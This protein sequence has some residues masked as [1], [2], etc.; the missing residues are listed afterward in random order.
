MS[1]RYF[2]VDF[3]AELPVMLGDITLEYGSFTEDALPF[4]SEHYAKLFGIEDG[5][6]ARFLASPMTPAKVRFSEEMDVFLHRHEGR[7]VG[8]HLC[9]PSDWCSYYMRTTL[10]LPEYRNRRLWWLLTDWLETPLSRAG[11]ERIE[12]DVCPT[13]VPMMSL[14]LRKRWTITSTMSSERWGNLVRLTHFFDPN[15]RRIF[16]RQ[17]CAMT[18]RPASKQ[19]EGEQNEEVRNRLLLS[20]TASA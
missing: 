4:L 2:G 16:E 18:V 17:F 11:V 13:N 1:E 12:G 14:A 10:I 15:A 7:V 5:G 9:H 6:A 3:G 19:M 20:A 8:L